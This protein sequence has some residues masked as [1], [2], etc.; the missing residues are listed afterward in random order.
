MTELKL[1]ENKVLFDEFWLN[2]PN[3]KNK[4]KAREIFAKLS[5]EDKKSAIE[6]AKAFTSYYKREETP[7]RFML[8]PTTYLN[9]ERWD[10]DLSEDEGWDF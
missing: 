6:G 4:K 8:H 2:W 7:K 9:N 10:D 5:L 1:V 3:K